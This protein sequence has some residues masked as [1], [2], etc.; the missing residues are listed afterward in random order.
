MEKKVMYNET[1]WKKK[2]MYNWTTLKKK[3]TREKK[4]YV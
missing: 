2:V 4:S 1:T 3:S